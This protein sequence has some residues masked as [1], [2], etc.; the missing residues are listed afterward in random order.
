MPHLCRKETDMFV[1]TLT[2]I[3][4]V[5]CIASLVLL[6]SWAAI[7]GWIRGVREDADAKAEAMAHEAYIKLTMD[8]NSKLAECTRKER[9]LDSRLMEHSP[10]G[11]AM[12]VSPD[13]HERKLYRGIIA[14]MVSKDTNSEV[15][16]TPDELAFVSHFR[17]AIDTNRHDGRVRLRIR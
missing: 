2:D 6:V 10:I 11:R 16:I 17:L 15:I 7:V 4:V 3:A 5:F 9:E 13:D 14:A 12:T 1:Y 8:L